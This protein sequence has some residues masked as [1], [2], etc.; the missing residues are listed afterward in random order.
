MGGN[1]AL[2]L[3]LGGIGAG[4]VLVAV[5][6]IALV[7]PTGGWV[8]AVPVLAGLACVA[9]GL[10]DWSRRPADRLGPLVML[11]GAA[12]MVGGLQ[13]T[14]IPALAAA[15]AVLA[16]AGFAAAVH[17]LPAV[18]SRA[19][20]VGAFLGCG[21]LQLSRCLLAPDGPPAVAAAGRALE[22][23]AG[24]LVV[25]G[26]AALLSGRWQ[27]PA[28]IREPAGP[29]RRDADRRLPAEL[30]PTPRDRSPEVL[31][32]DPERAVADL[33]AAREELHRS[34]LRIVEATDRERRRI[35]RDL[36]DGLQVRMVLLAIDAQRLAEVPAGG[37]EV[38]RVATALRTGIDEAAAQLR[39]AVQEIMPAPLV[40][41]GLSSA[42]EDLL[43]RAPLAARVDLDLP[44]RLPAAAEATAYFI[45]AEAVANTLKHAAA[46][47]VEVRMT[48]A[49]GRLRVEVRDDGD[50]GAVPGGGSGL[51]GLADRV[52]ALGGHLR[53]HS[54]KGAG[55]A[56]VVELPCGS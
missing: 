55:T 9:A 17:L 40:E 5:T 23:A 22:S 32:A 4:A 36:H 30:A 8:G 18:P 7:L 45:V 29:V 54:P 28:P 1:S 25:L 19:A 21:V 24:V 14:P 33:R 50:G 10:R 42:V 27:R 56:L 34:R 37:G 16:T 31:V 3:A 43:D 52:D 20:V 6:E 46:T 35:A 53:L 49:S 39:A 51:T 41:R 26:T 48:A 38:R 47:R 11:A 44:D 15:G 12:T 13:G 2:D